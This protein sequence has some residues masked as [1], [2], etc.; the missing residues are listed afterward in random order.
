MSGKLL[1]ALL[2]AA[3]VQLAKFSMGVD[4]LKI[5]GRGRCASSQ[6]VSNR[7]SLSNFGGVDFI[8]P[9]TPST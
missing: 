6:A 7:T 5:A 3:A 1:L 8:R 9:R 2:S 4:E